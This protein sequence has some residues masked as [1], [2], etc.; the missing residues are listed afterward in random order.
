MN[1]PAAAQ[2]P[3]SRLKVRSIIELRCYRDI[4][5]CASHADTHLIADLADQ[6]R[7]LRLTVRALLPSIWHRPKQ[8]LTH[9]WIVAMLETSGDQLLEVESVHFHIVSHDNLLLV[10]Q[11]LAQTPELASAQ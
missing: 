11:A 9:P 4:A 6:G 7:C 3:D 5:Y 8:L 10:D 2:L 1:N